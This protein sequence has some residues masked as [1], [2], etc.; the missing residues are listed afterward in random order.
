MLPF[1]VLDLRASC[2]HDSLPVFSL[3]RLSAFE[4]NVTLPSLVSL[5]FGHL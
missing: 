5:A 1:W 3:N 2:H 4:V